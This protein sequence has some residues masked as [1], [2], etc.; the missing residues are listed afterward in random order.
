MRETEGGCFWRAGGDRE[1]LQG[2]AGDRKERFEAE[3][4]LDDRASDISHDTHIF[5][6][7]FRLGKADLQIPLI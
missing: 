3:R 5:T 1:R 4:L 6:Y 2:F 7:T